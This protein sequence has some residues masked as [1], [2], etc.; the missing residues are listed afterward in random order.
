MTSREEYDFI[1]I[2]PTTTI[3]PFVGLLKA[4]NL[5]RKPLII[6]GFQ[7][8]VIGYLGTVQKIAVG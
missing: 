5:K 3:I 1:S 6:R 8:L 7:L 4:E 2:L